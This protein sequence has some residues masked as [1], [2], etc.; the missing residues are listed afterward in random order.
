MPGPGVPLI[1]MSV[2]TKLRVSAYVCLRVSTREAEG[3]HSCRNL[4]WGRCVRASGAGC[5]SRKE[6]H[7]HLTL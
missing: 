5:G 6:T 2:Y 1:C 7:L 4:S 3:A